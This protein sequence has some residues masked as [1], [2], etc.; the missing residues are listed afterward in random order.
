MSTIQD[1]YN[2]INER[3][4]IY[5]RRVRGDQPPW[6]E[7]EILSKYKFTN[8]FREN[9]K[10]TIWMRNNWTKPHQSPIRRNDI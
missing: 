8:P 6:T 2:W 9:D 3:H 1:F 4:A 10:V 7:D 5:Q